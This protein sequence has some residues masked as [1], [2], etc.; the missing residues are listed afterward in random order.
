MLPWSKKFTLIIGLLAV[1]AVYVTV[2]QLIFDGRLL[3]SS[4][5]FLFQIVVALMST[6]VL[7]LVTGFLFI[8]QS[9]IE[10]RSQNNSKVFETK[11]QFY[12]NAVERIADIAKKEINIDALDELFLLTARSMLVASP[13]AAERLAT[14]YE[15]FQKDEPGQAVAFKEFVLAARE[16]LTLIDNLTK[17][18]S[19]HF[20]KI[21]ETIE[22]SLTDQIKSVT[23]NTK[24]SWTNEQKRNI[25]KEYYDQADGHRYKWLR[26]NHNVTPAHIS[27]WK[28]QINYQD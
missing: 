2:F 5:S 17:G 3:G 14:L 27:T 12:E 15:V 8:F 4:E 11:I 21:L 28:T 7:A 16:D 19:T 10:S 20:D 24:R 23:A 25:I 9:E 26:D 18:H 13:K 1:S 22:N 6:G